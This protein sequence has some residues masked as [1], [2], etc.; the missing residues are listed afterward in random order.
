M[1][2]CHCLA[3]SDGDIRSVI[4]WMRA[5]DPGTIV[6]AGKV[7]RALGK[8]PDCGGCIGLFV[9]TMRDSPDFPVSLSEGAPPALRQRV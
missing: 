4:S 2:V 1:I 7:Y 5:S 3:I 9:E 8:R 6:T